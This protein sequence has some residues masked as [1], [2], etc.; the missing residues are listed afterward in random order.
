M[1]VGVQVAERRSRVCSGLRYT[2]YGGADFNWTTIELS[3]VRLPLSLVTSPYLANR[4]SH[5]HS[6]KSQA[7][8]GLLSLML[9]NRIARPRICSTPPILIDSDGHSGSRVTH[10]V[11]SYDERTSHVPCLQLLPS[12]DRV[13]RPC[14]N[15]HTS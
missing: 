10:R 3:P 4:A 15:Q 7:L 8:C 11:S 13:D 14:D 12:P 6:R 9:P 5:R 1:G 2:C